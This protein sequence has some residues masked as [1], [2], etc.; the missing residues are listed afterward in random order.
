MKE[1][2]LILASILLIILICKSRAS[3]KT[4]I[5]IKNFKANFIRNNNLSKKAQRDLGDFLM[6]NPERDIIIS[7]YENEHELQEKV[8]VHR[9]RLNKYGKSKINGELIYIGPRGGVFKL[10]VKGNKQYF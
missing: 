10:S 8:D 1:F 5:R 7:G 9:A 3:K 2:I 6:G 4:R